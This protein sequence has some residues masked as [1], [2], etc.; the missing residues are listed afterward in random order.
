MFTTNYAFVT[1]A[2]LASNASYSINAVIADDNL[3][4]NTLTRVV[5]NTNDVPA[6]NN[7]NGFYDL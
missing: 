2:D 5:Y 3:A 6:H 1:T 7:T 4:N